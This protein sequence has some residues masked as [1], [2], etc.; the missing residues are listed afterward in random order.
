MG[1]TASCEWYALTPSS[2]LQAG[3][4][5][6]ISTTYPHCFCSTNPS[7]SRQHVML[8]P[9]SVQFMSSLQHASMCQCSACPS[10]TPPSPLIHQH[11]IHPATHQPF[12]PSTNTI[13]LTSHPPTIP[14]PHPPVQPSTR[15]P[16]TPPTCEASSVSLGT[17]I[18]LWS[19]CSWAKISDN[20]VRGCSSASSLRCWDCTAGKWQGKQQ[21]EQGG[22]ALRIAG[23]LV[24]RC[25]QMSYRYIITCRG[26]D[27]RG[28][29]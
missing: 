1:E 7:C 8:N 20:V 19:G 2:P 24:P 17:P 14:L 21:A 4:S 5:T 22:S 27:T 15:H 11:T 13:Y 29:Q 25:E 28:I 9:N 16:S 10:L 12:P 3:C 26:H 18:T 6:H 23:V